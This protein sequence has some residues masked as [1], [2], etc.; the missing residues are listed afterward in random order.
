MDKVW[1]VARKIPKSFKDRFP[2]IN[3]I[4]LQLLYNRG[5][6]TKKAINDFLLP[7]YSQGL[8]D[9]FIFKDM[10]RAV[11]RI[12]SAIDKKEKIVICTDFDTDGA[13][14]GTLLSTALKK[15]G[16]DNLEI[17]VPDRDA[18][19]YGLNKQ[20]VKTFVQQK[21]G[22]LITCDCGISNKDEVDLA[23]KGGID[24]IVTDHH[25]EPEELPQALAILNSQLS[26]EKYPNQYLAGVGVVFK[27]VQALLS[28]QKCPIANK[29]AVEKW[30]LDLVAVGTV[31]DCMKL[32]GENRVLVKYGLIV[33][34]KTANIGL[35]SLI[36]RAGLT[37]GEIDSKS[38]SHQIGPRLN[39][40]GR[41]GQS[42]G[43]VK[44][45]LSDNEDQADALVQ[46]VEL[47][48]QNRQ[49]MV[50]DIIQ[51][52]ISKTGPKPK[53]K[54]LVVIGKD[55]PSGLVGLIATRLVD[56]YGRPTIVLNSREIGVKG[57]GRSGSGSGFNL[58][59]AISPLKK[60]FFDFGGHSAAI[61]FTLKNA[62]E[63]DDFKK[64][65]LDIGEKKLKLK[66]L[67]YKMN[68]EV[69]VDL[70]DIDWDMYEE[71]AKFEPFGQDN[72]QPNF[73]A[74]NIYLNSMQ[75]VGKN[76]QHCRLT[77]GSQS[78]GGPARPAGGPARPAGGPARPAGGQSRQSFDAQNLG[79]Q[80]GR[81]MIYFG[82]NNK[83]RGFKIGDKIDVIF[84]LGINQWNGRQ[85]LQMKVI[86]LRKTKKHKNKKT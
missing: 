23:N 63:V 34:N 78:P 75:K 29:E 76:S 40:S 69:Q 25:R 64:S 38:I 37:L 31:T 56:H 6:K 43:A 33:L 11:K 18:E 81:K 20:A 74:K 59:D 7:D 72:F 14:S 27:L 24:V 13:V 85:E 73:L 42:D 71:L 21:T 19:G 46:Q 67:V 30:F 66:P 65:V 61:G 80:S 51:K 4:I 39:V 82:A 3:P 54:I 12:Y 15:I 47:L 16:A 17:Y 28:D 41:I 26:R 1:K 68:I 36:K 32:I 83:M 2:E 50:N 9:P 5:L 86:D 8:H 57:S 22:L 58:F 70:D 10:T 52:L 77:A 45:L 44:L 48:N 35:R 79:G 60:Y 53:E 49:Q 55:W 62:D 84:Q